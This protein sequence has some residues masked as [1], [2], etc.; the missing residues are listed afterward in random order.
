VT[1]RSPI[2]VK[3]RKPGRVLL[4][5]VYFFFLTVGILALGYVAYVFVD[6]HAFQA[7]AESRLADIRPTQKPRMVAL[8]DVIGEM[9]IPRLN[10]KTI[11]LQGESSKALR[12]AIGHLPETPMPGEPGNVAIA[13]HRDTFFRPLRGIRPGDAITIKTPA[14]EFQYQVEST[15]VVL[16]NDIQVLEPSPGNTLTLVTCFPF[17]YVGSAPKRFIVHA[18]QIFSPAAQYPSSRALPR[19]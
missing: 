9:M 17:F 10:L 12:R 11:V 6:A 8:G 1:V 7:I 16:P 19:L 13:G 2:P 4:R 5:A 15:E 3:H 14:G 18:R